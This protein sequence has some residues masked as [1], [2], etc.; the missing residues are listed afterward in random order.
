LIFNFADQQISSIVKNVFAGLIFAALWAS[1]S[2]A[3]KFG[4]M[5]A[6]PFTIALSRFSIAAL[7][8]LAYTHLIRKN[9]LPKRHEWKPLMIYGFL[10][11][12]LY[13]GCYVFAMKEVS[14]GI[15]SL[16]V[17]IGPLIISVIS[18]LW[19]KRAIKQKEI[20]SL[21]LGLAGIAVATYPLLL[22]SY[23]SISGL[24]ILAVSMLSYSVATVYYSNVNWQLQRLTINAWQIT[25]GGLFLLPIA[26]FFYHPE[27][28][29]F[30]NRFWFSILW[31]VIPVSIAAVNLWLFLVKID[32]VR[33]SVWLFL[34]PIFGFIYAYFLLNEPITT[35]T[36]AGTALVIAGQ[37]LVQKKQS[38]KLE[39]AE[40]S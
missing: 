27:Q 2:A 15:G 40:A 36:F 34:C 10:N 35:Y 13:L 16:S 31:L 30:D 37:L 14:A 21:C 38:Q 20:I 7:L 25:F 8:M 17:A 26:L 33:A 3:T 5:S 9:S 32:T 1:A 18:A 23:A 28:N 19:L 22:R 4:L 29:N 12:T 39:S 24:V 6:Q 11:I